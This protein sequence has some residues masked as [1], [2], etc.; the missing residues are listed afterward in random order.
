[1]AEYIVNLDYVDPTEIVRSWRKGIHK[2]VMP[3][4]RPEN[5]EEILRLCELDLIE[6]GAA[7]IG[8]SLL[9]IT[10]RDALGRE[11]V[12]YA[13]ENG[14]VLSVDEAYQKVQRLCKEKEKHIGIKPEELLINV[15]S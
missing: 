11:K 13:D 12:E 3:Y 9:E 6:T 7:D 15:K 4:H 2:F 10:T 5:K 8:L 1:M 14:T